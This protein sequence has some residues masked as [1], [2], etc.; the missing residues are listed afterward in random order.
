MVVSSTIAEPDTGEAV[1]VSGTS[2]TLG[3]KCILLSTHKVYQRVIAGAGTTAPNLDLTNWVEVGPTNRWAMFDIYRNSPSVFN[4]ATTVVLA[5]GSRVDSIAIMG[6]RVSDVNVSIEHDG[7]V[8]YT[9][10]AP[11]QARLVVDYYDYFYADFNYKNSVLML[12]IPPVLNPII[13]ITTSQQGSISSIVIGRQTYIGMTRT[14]HTNNTL[15]FS[16]IDRDTYGTTTLIPRRNIPRTS[17]E[18]VVHKKDVNDVLAIRNALRASPAVWSG[19]D[20]DT[21]DYFEALLILGIY[22]EMTIS[23]D[24]PEY[25]T[26]TL[27]LEE[28]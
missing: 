23:L 19:L 6:A 15:N 12:S 17:Q 5:P 11:M 26:C 13:T 27:E 4:A 16:V 22:K 3:Q 18:I 7:E 28:I 10:S 21:E 1:W 9:Y 20:D 24:Y 8:I 25:A 2:Y 14:G